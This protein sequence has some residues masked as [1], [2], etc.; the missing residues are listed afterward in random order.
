MIRRLYLPPLLLACLLAACTAGD[1]TGTTPT[2]EDVL[3]VTATLS[4]EEAEAPSETDTPPPAPEPVVGRVHLGAPPVTIDP[5]AAIQ[6][7]GAASDLVANMFVGLTALNPDTRQ[8]EPALATRWEISEDGQTWTVYLRDDVYWVQVDPE[9]G[10]VERVRPVTA[11]DVVT[12]VQRACQADTAAPQASAV[13]VIAGCRFLHAQDPDLLTPEV[14]EQTL[15]ARVLNDVA[16]EFRLGSETVHFPSIMA[17]PVM[18]PVPT[19]LIESEG[20]GW[21]DPALIWTSGPFALQPTIPLAEGATLV[22]NPFWPLPR[23]GNLDAVQVSFDSAEVDPAE[24]FAAW[25]EE[26][27]DLTVVPDSALASAPFGD[28]PAYWLLGQPVTGMVV[29]SYDTPPF[30][31]QAVRQAFSLALDREAVV[32]DILLPAG[33]AALP[34]TEITP[35]GSADAPAYGTVGLGYDPEAA[36]EV[37]AEEGFAN[38]ASIPPT[39]ILTHESDLALALAND[40]VAMWEA[41]LG[42]P[43]GL[44]TVEQRPLHEIL[45]ALQE[46]PVGLEDRRAGLAILTWEADYPDAYHWLADIFGCRDLFPNAYLNQARACV[47]ADERLAESAHLGEARAA[48]IETVEQAFLGAGGEVPVIPVFHYARPLA[49]QPWLA[50]APLDA[51]PLRFDQ[52]VLDPAQR[53]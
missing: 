53:P 6:L 39:T 23:A 22:A 43:E 36:A 7:D 27:L 38:C 16:V 3:T 21:T 28:N 30:N 5:G 29:F 45:V 31:N 13:F 9:G 42:C 25:Q 20:E 33:Q 12:A 32:E 52:W 4:P 2:P 51:G 18:H 26:R 17:M 37:M 8:V 15:G 49:I 40:Y 48:R 1:G 14:I 44:F 35:P 10:E 19:D 11:G 41:A 50:I 47:E 24:A 34:A 46:P